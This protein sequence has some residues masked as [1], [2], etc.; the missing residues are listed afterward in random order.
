MKRTIG[1]TSSVD[2]VSWTKF[3]R[4][5]AMD[6][7]HY[8]ISG[9]GRE[10]FGSMFNYHPDDK[11]LN[12]R[13]NLYYVQTTDNGKSWRTIDDQRLEIPLT[14]TT[15]PALVRDYETE[16]LN[17]YLK[18]LQFDHQDHPVLL[19]ITS[20][21]YQSGPAND[22]R[23]W[24]IAR[25]TG[26]EW[27]FSEITTS[28]NNYDFGELWIKSE[29]EWFLIAPTEP[30]PQAF[31]PGGEIAMWASHDAGKTWGK[32]KQLTSESQRN[33]TYVRNV[34]NAHPDF[35]SIWADGHGRKPSDS[36]LFFSDS[37]G[38]VFQL[39]QQMDETAHPIPMKARH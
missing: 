6:E 27:K 29:N 17:V 2:G 34:H 12:W 16:G 28:D 30:G 23:T 39:P 38:N 3:Q 10:R 37:N 4:L 26:F 35:V 8:Q 33:H 32:Q 18:D 31:N 19:Y 36:K 13:T 25:W 15:G 20:K 7:G 24:T 21:G 14:E 9:M 22:P 11:G 5:A 1:F